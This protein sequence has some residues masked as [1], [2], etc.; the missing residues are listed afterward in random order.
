MLYSHIIL[1][2]LPFPDISIQTMKKSNIVKSPT[3]KKQFF[4]TTKI[5]TPDYLLATPN[6]TSN[7]ARR[8]YLL[9]CLL[10]LPI[11]SNEMS[12]VELVA[13]LTAQAPCVFL[14]LHVYEVVD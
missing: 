14:N 7:Q 10:F 8:C 12:A 9:V 13:V 5:I 1:R 11:W 2:K 4:L 6:P 3:D